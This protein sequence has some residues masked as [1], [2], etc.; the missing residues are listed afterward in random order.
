MARFL[1]SEQQVKDA[2][3]IRDF[4]EISKDKIKEFV[5]LIPNMDQE[6]AIAIINQFPAYTDFANNA[7]AQLNS[8]CETII[9]DNNSSQKEAVEAYRKILD[10]L[11]FLLKKEYLTK[12]ERD[13][14]TKKMILVADK[15]SEKDSE[16]KRFLNGIFT[17]GASVLGVFLLVGAAILGVKGDDSKFPPLIR[18]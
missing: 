15:I 13:E 8:I 14:I 18:S 6:V 1:L 5:S 4:R 7:I 9:K 17:V 3:R 12:E 16:N 11:S 2:L 10:E